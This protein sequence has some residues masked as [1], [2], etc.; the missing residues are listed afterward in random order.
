MKTTN[1]ENADPEDKR[2]ILFEGDFHTG[3]EIE[4]IKKSRQISKR[5]TARRVRS[6]NPIFLKGGGCSPR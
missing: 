5:I 6:Y 3:A 4:V 2:L 1:N